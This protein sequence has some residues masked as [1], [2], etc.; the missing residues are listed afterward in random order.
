MLNTQ[1]C[2]KQTR[3]KNEIL[4]YFPPSFFA[5]H[6]SSCSFLR[7]FRESVFGG[8]GAPPGADA[9]EVP[10]D[11]EPV[12]K[13]VGVD[14]LLEVAPPFAT[15]P[16]AFMGEILKAPI[17]GE[18]RA[19]FPKEMMLGCPGDRCPPTIRRAA[20]G[21]FGVPGV[22]EVVVPSPTTLPGAGA[23]GA[24][25]FP[26]ELVVPAVVVPAAMTPSA[27]SP[28]PDGT[29]A[30]ACTTTCGCACAG[31]RG[32]KPHEPSCVTALYPC[33]HGCCRLRVSAA[34]TNWLA[35]M[36]CRHPHPTHIHHPPN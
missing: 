26:G 18:M 15:P 4:C 36:D 33:P 12:R 31:A 25:V 34:V 14:G 8:S 11:A 35:A 3:R 13:T 27:C 5:F 2:A 7:S 24:T 1:R 17:L 30:S 32:S 23:A 10:A 20:P 28:P 21:L 19:E 22:L 6:L 9:A 16:L 29:T